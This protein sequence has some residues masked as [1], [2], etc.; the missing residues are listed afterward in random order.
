M[1][2]YIPRGAERVLEIGCGDGNF[3]NF[4]SSCEYWG[5]EPNANVKQIESS[6]IFKIYKCDYDQAY[7]QIPNEYFDLV[8]VN[9]VVEHMTDHD[10]FFSSIKKKMTKGGF[11]L[12]SVP[13]VRHISN[14]IN[15]IYHKDWHYQSSGILDRTHFRFFTKKSLIRTF[16]LHNYEIELVQPINRQLSSKINVKCFCERVICLFLGSDT[17]FNQ[18]LFCVKNK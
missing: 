3:V 12:G 6:N 17:Q 1:S 4:F 15:L 13:N 5:V 7:D 11:L 18:L 16:N 8:I 10:Y 14:I 9:D 2:E